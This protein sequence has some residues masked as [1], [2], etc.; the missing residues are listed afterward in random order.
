M[1][2]FINSE[3]IVEKIN[4]EVGFIKLLLNEGG[5]SCILKTLI[6]TFFSGYH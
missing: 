1:F 3:L 4:S 2:Q 6:K 5:K